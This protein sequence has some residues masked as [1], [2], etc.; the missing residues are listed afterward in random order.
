MV[1]SGAK[2]TNPAPK[3]QFVAPVITQTSTTTAYVEPVQHSM[4]QMSIDSPAQDKES[5]KC[6]H[7]AMR[8]YNALVTEMEQ[9][10]L[11]AG[12]QRTTLKDFK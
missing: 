3:K 6:E 5:N 4:E 9:S 7:D 1:D 12:K 8:D 2:S 11:K 10:Q